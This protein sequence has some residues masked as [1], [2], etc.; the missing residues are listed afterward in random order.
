VDP[1]AL[2]TQLRAILSQTIRAGFDSC[3]FRLDRATE[4]PQD[5]HLVV[6]EGGQDKDVP[7]DLSGDP[8]WGPGSG[9][10]VA[11]DGTTVELTGR[12][13]DLAKAGNYESVRFDYGCVEFPPPD[14]PAG[15]I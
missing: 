13:C 15:P 11:A 1:A 3:T 4:V 10:T 5:L 9:W 8:N 14:A 6:T 12:L 7:R 2:E